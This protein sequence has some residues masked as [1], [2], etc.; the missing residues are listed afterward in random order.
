M[1]SIII[2]FFLLLFIFEIC[3]RI[4]NLNDLDDTVNKTIE[5]YDGIEN[6]F[7][8]ENRVHLDENTAKKDEFNEGS[9]DVQE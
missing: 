5:E 8:S 9:L 1:I 2:L 6:C 7:S 4:K 3:R